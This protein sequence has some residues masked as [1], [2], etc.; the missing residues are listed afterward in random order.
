M[1][2]TWLRRA[3]RVALAALPLLPLAAMAQEAG[4][5]KYG[6]LGLDTGNM[7]RDVAPGDDFYSYME[8]NWVDH[9]SIPADKTR[10]GYNYDLEDKVAEEVRA[11][12]ENAV[13]HPDTPEAQRI[14]AVWTAWMDEKGITARGVATLQP[15][16]ARIAAIKTRRELMQL[17]AEPGYTSAIGLAITADSKDPARYVVR[18][19]QGD[20][21][22]PARDYYLETGEKYDAVR[23]AYTA[24]IAQIFTL[25]GVS[26]ADT[27]A[28]A[29][30]ALETA[31]AKDDWAPERLRDPVA[32]YNPVATAHLAAYAPGIDW[33]AMLDK[34]GLAKAKVVVVGEPSA[35]RAIGTHLARDPIELWK[36][37][38]VFRLI[39][40][41][42]STLPVAFDDA[43]FAFYGKV[44]G[45]VTEQRPRWKRGVDLL[46]QE[47]GQDVG[48]IYLKTHWSADAD[49]QMAEMI[50]DLKGSYADR[51]GQA[52]WMDGPTRAAAL[53]KLA[54]FEARVAGPKTPI[55]YS[56]F[57][58][59]A[60]DPFANAIEAQRFQWAL[61]LKRYGGPVDRGVWDMNPQTVN[62]YYNPNSNQVTFPAAELLPPFFD[63]N[64]DPAVN[65][66]AAG[67]TI[68]HEMGH[69]F[70]DEGR[71]FDGQGRLKN[72]W[73]RIS[74]EKFKVH[75]DALVKQYDAYEP[76]PGLHIK[77][78]L[79]LGENL[80]DLGGLEA[81]YAAYHRYLKRHGEAETI[82]GMTGDQRFFLSYAQSWQSKV[83][84]EA[85]RQQLL[86]DPHSP[87]TFRVNGVV[88]NVDAWYEAFNVAP[89][90]K[91]YLP[92]DQRVHV[93]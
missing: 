33:G 93:W 50:D 72:W 70:D 92:P 87:D 78:A 59:V 73:T 6:S 8:G 47:L 64:A 44:L 10:I 15:M 68:G 76:V 18:A 89:D 39:S 62:A 86:G 13:A 91:L 51:I 3:T 35:V 25:A 24:Y 7:N 29:I 23:K 48:Q 11:I 58:P 71:Q 60:D 56:D 88:R 36:D 43:H 84:E 67:A 32:T 20:L 5:P 61:W 75:A 45:G 31:L 19:D 69:G 55:D 82:D 90:S 46:N 40:D 9:T 22:L 54:A 41:L 53:A 12:A 14:A 4:A 34:L 63:P 27:R 81:A 85:L 57:H 37:Y 30:M 42:A 74:A 52:N 26:D 66:G 77:G 21:G 80:A 1:T 16:V 83:R 2:T 65:Y 79:T 38:L 17:M 28:T 49:A